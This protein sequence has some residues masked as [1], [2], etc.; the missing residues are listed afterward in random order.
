MCQHLKVFRFQLLWQQLLTVRVQQPTTCQLFL[1]TVLLQLRAAILQLVAHALYL[2]CSPTQPTGPLPSSDPGEGAAGQLGQGAANMGSA[3]D[4]THGTGIA[5][6]QGATMQLGESSPAGV[7]GSSTTWPGLQAEEPQPVTMRQLRQ[8]VEQL[9]SVHD[10]VVNTL[11]QH[12]NE[13]T[14]DGVTEEEDNVPAEGSKAAET[15]ENLHTSLRA[16]RSS[17]AAVQQL[18][19]AASSSEA[20]AN[21]QERGG[22]AIDRLLTSQARHISGVA[23]QLQALLQSINGRSAVSHSA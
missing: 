10:D 14:R 8:L 19:A 22:D 16:V 21:P 3:A 20:S 13:A 5:Q 6:Q 15:L 9:S 1:C 7:S 2:R 18:M 12:S 17:V 4:G 23:Q 11:E